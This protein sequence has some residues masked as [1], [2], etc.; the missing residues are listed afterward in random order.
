MTVLSPI[1]GYH[2]SVWVVAGVLV[3][4]GHT[5][6]PRLTAWCTECVRHAN[7]GI[8]GRFLCVF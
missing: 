6:R 1:V 2:E 7:R 8:T 3:T 4:E 5:K